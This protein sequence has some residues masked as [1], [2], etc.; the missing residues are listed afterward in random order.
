MKE[1]EVSCKEGEICQ[2]GMVVR[3]LEKSIK[4]Y[5]YEFRLGPWYIWKFEQPEL[6]E[7]FYKGIKLEKS[8]FKLALAKIGPMQYE[9]LQPL[10]GLGIHQE[11]LDKKGEGLHHM[12][13]YFKNIPKALMDFQN[14]GFYPIQEGRYK[15]DMYVYLDAERS[16]G[17]IYEI[18]NCG[19][20]GV[21]ISKY[22]E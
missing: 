15:D 13:L 21:P 22:P 8:G 12:R 17:I 1:L 2:I 3:N 9:L 6:R 16:Y 11:Y 18:G 7:V 4:K 19:D 14:K 10:Y 5:W 20:I